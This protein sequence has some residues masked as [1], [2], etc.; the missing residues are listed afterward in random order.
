MGDNKLL[1]ALNAIGAQQASV[2]EAT[3]EAVT[4]LLNYVA[5]YPNDGILYRACDM[6]FA[7]NADEGFHNETKGRSR[8]EEC[9]FLA[10][11]E[12]YPRWNR[13][14]LIVF[15]IIKFAMASAAKVEFGALFITD[16]K[17]LPIRQTLIQIWDG[18]SPLHLFKQIIQQQ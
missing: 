7:A 5:T 3:N 13:A 6:V 4:T 17:I 18:P 14:I 9:I 1:V 8:A 12:P 2:T 15:Q 10:K 11:D 16:Q